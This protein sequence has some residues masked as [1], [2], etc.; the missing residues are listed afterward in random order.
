MTNSFTSNGL[1][2]TEQD[3]LVVVRLVSSALTVILCTIVIISQIC[4]RELRRLQGRIVHFLMWSAVVGAL[5]DIY[6]FDTLDLGRSNTSDDSVLCQLQAVQSQAG[7]V[8]VIGWTV[9]VTLNLYLMVDKRI[10]T[11]ESRMYELFF[12][13]G[14][15]TAVA[16]FATLPYIGLTYG[17]DGVWC[18]IDQSTTMGMVWTYFAFYVPLWCAIVVV[19]VLYILTLR[20]VRTA[21]GAL[22]RSA[23]SDGEHHQKG[24][25]RLY[26]YPVIFVLIWIIPTIDQIVVTTTGR[27][28]FWLALPHA[29]L[30]SSQGFL[31]AMVWGCNE[32]VIRFLQTYCC[33]CCQ[34][35]WGDLTLNEIRENVPGKKAKKTVA[36]QSRDSGGNT[37]NTTPS[38]TTGSGSGP[39]RV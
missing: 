2:Q 11:S 32:R 10:D 13:I 37:L 27:S 3:V 22:R 35:Y 29:I 20:A 6:V 30:A 4:L 1:T 5:A 31:N 25:R 38:S 39:D 9:I 17:R 33:C 23:K 28:H 21:F 8:A 16:L 12:H 19:V 34:K 15:W 14:V 7:D 18:W 26:T 24:M 36:R